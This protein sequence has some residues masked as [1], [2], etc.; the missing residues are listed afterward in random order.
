MLFVIHI[1]KLL[2]LGTKI[3]YK[4][5]P[6]QKLTIHKCSNFTISKCTKV[7]ISKCTNFTISKCK[8]FTKNKCTPRYEMLAVPACIVLVELSHPFY[9]PKEEI[10]RFGEK[11]RV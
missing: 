4:Y 9:R 6:F 7:T 1:C 10:L 2:A 8:N 11:C 3:S 5:F